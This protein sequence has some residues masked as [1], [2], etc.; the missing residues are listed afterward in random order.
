MLEVFDQNPQSRVFHVD[1][2]CYIVYLG[3]HWEDYK[4][5]LRLGTST[6]LPAE[7]PPIVST[8][9]VPDALT[10]NPLDEAACLAGD[11]TPDTHYVGDVET[12]EHMKRFVGQ[13]TIRVEAIEEIDHEEDDGKHVLVYYYR[14]GNLKIKYRKNEV[15]DLRRREKLDGHFVA[16]AQEA[17]NEYGRG[18]FKLPGD[19]YQRPGFLV[20]EG[21]PYLVARGEL[22]ALRLTEDYFFEL[23][24][25]GIDADR[26]STVQAEDADTALIRFFKRSRTRNRPVRVSTPRRERVEQAIDLF[27]ENS[28]PPLKAHV[29]EGQGGAFE[30]HRYVVTQAPG[31]FEAMLEE[32]GGPVVFGSAAK[33]PDVPLTVDPTAGTITLGASKTTHPLL[34]GA[35][36]QIGG[37]ALSRTTIAER[38]LPEKNYPY[39]DLLSQA[40]NTLLGQLEYFFN[41]LYA[42]RDTGRVVRTLKGLDP[43]KV[44]GRADGSIHPIAQVLL[45]NYAQ[46]ADFVRV[47]EAE[48]AKGVDALSNLLARHRVTRAEVPALI[49][50][51]G[52]IHRDGDDEYLFYRIPQ[53]ITSDRLAHAERVVENV[54]AA[55][56]ID[57]E[58]ERR[59]LDDLIAGLATPEQMDEARM[60]RIAEAK[61]RRKQSKPAAEQTVSGEPGSG[62]AS[63]DD[64]GT[65]AGA[66]RRGGAA[67]RRRGGVGGRGRS[68]RRRGGWVLPAAAAVLLIAA[69]IALLLTGTIPNPWFGDETGI[70]RAGNGDTAAAG[71]AGTSD[72]A[73]AEGD[74]EPTGADGSAAGD[75]A[76]DG[77]GTAAGDEDTTA[78]D[79]PGAEEG[80]SE[81]DSDDAVTDDEADDDAAITTDAGTPLP[82]GW[83]PD[84]LPALEALENAPGVTITGDRVI[85][86]GGIEI[87]LNDII[88]LVNE[89][90]IDNGYAP[91]DA[92]DPDRP[93]PDWIYPGNVFVLPNDTRYTVVGGDT[94]WEITVRY[95]VARLQQ[96][97][98]LF[99]RLVEEHEAV[100]TTDARR[101]EIAQRLEEIGETSH[102][103]NFSRM[104]DE[105]LDQW[106]E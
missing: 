44:I 18:P 88:R 85:G 69:L 17:K 92:V 97:Y 60:R 24:A 53:R 55:P 104:V 34:E 96:D 58:A 51:I 38:F 70:A 94:L 100:E 49:P 2:E 15:F 83:P 78:A 65:T 33:K 16:R 23:S 40:E 103:E 87:T 90:A 91:M 50:L 73:A 105:K 45:H 41:E 71:D 75:R 106:R 86:P 20:V 8:I 99:T 89:V 93:D 57:H 76:S 32:L 64:V 14:D 36:Y 80:A 27:P 102:T 35:L 31:R 84:S 30:F 101:R 72:E 46:Y 43:V 74:G 52:E 9:V 4:P 61:E 82:E 68:H 39:R 42:G 77:D 13:E 54:R 81:G 26:I 1:R 12:V 11:A 10:G 21:S 48:A 22:A 19:S 56:V 63:A 28:L 5:F 6:N 79:G 7:L 59:R 37:E 62:E 47:H 95:M 67:D 98:E 25:A 66:G 29:V 3:S